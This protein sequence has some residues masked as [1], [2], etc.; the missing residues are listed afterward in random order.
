MIVRLIKL[1]FTLSIMISPMKSTPYRKEG[2]NE[3]DAL[4][5]S[6]MKQEN[7]RNVIERVILRIKDIVNY[8]SEILRQKDQLLLIYTPERGDTNWIDTKL[9][10]DNQ[11]TLSRVFTFGIEE[12]AEGERLDLPLDETRI[13]ILGIVCNNFFKIVPQ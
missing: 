9:Q 11:V 2:C 7:G 10:S 13:F 1:L 8:P 5:D 12:L 4:L 6:L 3:Y